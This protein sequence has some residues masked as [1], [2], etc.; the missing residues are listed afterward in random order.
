MSAKSQISAITHAHPLCTD[1]CV[2][3]N[4]I[5]AALIDGIESGNALA[6]AQVLDLHPHVRDALAV[7]ADALVARLSTFG[8]VIASLRC[9]V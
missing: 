7:S 4:E 5:A 1:S 2:G 9:A 3:Y 6:R 8:Y